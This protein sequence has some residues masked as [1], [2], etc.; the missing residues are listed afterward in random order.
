MNVSLLRVKHQK[1][2][3]CAHFHE[4][5]LS[6][7]QARLPCH[8]KTVIKSVQNLNVP[9]CK[10]V[11]TII[12]IP[13]FGAEVKVKNGKSWYCLIR[14]SFSVYQFK[15]KKATKQQLWFGVHRLLVLRL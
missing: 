15:K 8:E 7:F 13:H 12:F 10:N 2:L 6:R 4:L 1:I 3:N 9:K 5:R 14:F 11:T